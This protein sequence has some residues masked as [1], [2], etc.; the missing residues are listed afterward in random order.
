MDSMPCKRSSTRYNVT[1]YYHPPMDEFFIRIYTDQIKDQIAEA[2]K[3]YS[4]ISSAPTDHDLVFSA[5]HHF[6]IHVSN[7]VKL[8]QPNIKDDNDFR[9][10]RSLSIRKAYP[11]IPD[12]NPKDIG[13][14]NDF[15]H[16]DERIDYWVINSKSHN[17]MDKSIGN[18]GL[19]QAVAGID[20]KDSFRWFNFQEM[21]LSFCGKNYDLKSLFDYIGS[22]KSVLTSTSI[23]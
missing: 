2:E 12:L 1:K 20:S 11:T 23:L 21:T 18:I 8:L 5:I 4:L 22:V 3:A 16:F 19:G 17:Y 10:F 14:R 15:E 7:V 6:I 9:K 13:I